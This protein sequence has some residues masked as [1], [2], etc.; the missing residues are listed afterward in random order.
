MEQALNEEMIGQ[1]RREYFIHEQNIYG[2]SSDWSYHQ[3]MKSSSDQSYCQ[4]MKS[5]SDQSYHQA[6]KSPKHTSID[7]AV[8]RTAPFKQHMRN[9]KIEVFVT[10]LYKIDWIIKKKHLKEWQA[11][12]VEKYKL[13]Q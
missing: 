2:V 12:E 9:K 7:I 6:M 1:I 3:V 10:S 11:K 5:S 4:V 8:I 13:I